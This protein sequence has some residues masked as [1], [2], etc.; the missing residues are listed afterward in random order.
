LESE[1]ANAEILFYV[2]V[3]NFKNHVKGGALLQADVL[4]AEAIYSK[5]LKKSSPFE[6]KLPANVIKQVKTLDLLV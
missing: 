6:I 4:K 5:Y 1:K 3:D 2:D